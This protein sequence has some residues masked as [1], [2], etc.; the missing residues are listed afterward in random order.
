MS[1][2]RDL[3]GRR[4]VLGILRIEQIQ[5][6]TKTRAEESRA[7]VG[8]HGDESGVARI[9]R[10]GGSENATARAGLD[11]DRVTVPEDEAAI[12]EIGSHDAEGTGRGPG[13]ASDVLKGLGLGDGSKGYDENYRSH[14]AGKTRHDYSGSLERP[15]H[16]GPGGSRPEKIGSKRNCS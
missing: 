13:E 4:E 2:S 8:R 12:G 3:G 16:N 14:T 1:G 10:G 9:A 5:A 11:E 15:R 6:R 7:T